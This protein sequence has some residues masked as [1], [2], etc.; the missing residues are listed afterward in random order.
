MPREFQLLLDSH[1]GALKLLEKYAKELG[2]KLSFSKPLLSQNPS[3]ESESGL[4]S[5]NDSKLIVFLTIVLPFKDF[6]LNHQRKLVKIGEGKTL[7]KAKENAAL[8]GLKLIR[9]MLISDDIE[10]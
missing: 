7:P 8:E 9:T 2:A 1:G 5:P 10:E 3:S 6:K 4:L